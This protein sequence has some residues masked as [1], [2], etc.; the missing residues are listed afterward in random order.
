VQKAGL[1]SHRASKQ[2]RQGK[3][4]TF[5]TG[6]RARASVWSEVRLA[7]VYKKTKRTWTVEKKNG[8]RW[9][10]TDKRYVSC[11]MTGVMAAFYRRVRARLSHL[12]SEPYAHPSQSVEPPIDPSPPQKK[13]NPPRNSAKYCRPGANRS[14]RVSSTRGGRTGVVLAAPARTVRGRG[15]GRV[16]GRV[17]GRESRFC[18]TR[19]TNRVDRARGPDALGGGGGKIKRGGSNQ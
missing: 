16:R 3:A 12:V 19:L 1:S 2:P 4:R 17:R 11:Q 5:A 13:Y 7:E 8:R 15:R 10:A 18:P 6:K 14:G 9:R